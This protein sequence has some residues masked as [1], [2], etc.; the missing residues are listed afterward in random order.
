MS[1]PETTQSS[2]RQRVAEILDDRLKKRDGPLPVRGMGA[3]DGAEAIEAGR[4][5]LSAMDSAGF[6]APSWPVQH[7]GAGLNRDELS[8]L[9]AE[10]QPFEVPD[11]YPFSIGLGMA[12]PVIHEFGTPEQ[13]DRWLAAIRTGKE[14]WCQMFSEPD[15]GS[16][17]AGLTCR[18]EE[19][20]DGWRLTGQKVWTSRAHYSRWGLA[21]A[22]TDP[23]QPKHR[24]ITAFV[25]DMEA[26]GVD[27]RPLQQINGDLHFNE[28]FLENVWVP[29]TQ[30]IGDRGDGWRVAMKTLSHERGAGD[31]SIGGFTPDDVLRL[32]ETHPGYGPV[33]RQRLARAWANQRVAELTALRADAARA[34]GSDP[35]A[36]GSGSKL[37][38]VAGFK[39][40]ATLA[41]DLEGP[42]GLVGDGAW[43][44]LFLT[45]PSLSI[46][47]GTD[48]IQRNILGERVLGLPREVRVDADMPF[49]VRPRHL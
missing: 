13:Q 26:S 5:Y 16:D 11:L 8:V 44:T 7:G 33:M 34:G 43:V 40:L 9:A 38:N 39:E 4:T 41:L 27:L 31:R 30:R 19:D 49:N 45:A 14:I 47:G 3:G 21:L 6:A 20:G 46:R 37:R 23:D 35:G 10:L 17:L 15:A 36:A 2:F 12:G 32:A 48:E 25:V 24:G 18:A 29:D 22:R 28:V 1:S 42:S